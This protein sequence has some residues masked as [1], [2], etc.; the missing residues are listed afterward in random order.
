[1]DKSHEIYCSMKIEVQVEKSK[2]LDT[3][4]ESTRTQPVISFLVR[5][6]TVPS[7]KGYNWGVLNSLNTTIGKEIL[8]TV[9]LSQ[10]KEQGMFIVFNNRP[11]LIILD[12]NLGNLTYETRTE[13]LY[14]T[15]L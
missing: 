1:M 7:G 12:D 6:I 4:D 11:S 10:E 13:I 2:K 14:G 3:L 5:F 8:K 9:D 15:I